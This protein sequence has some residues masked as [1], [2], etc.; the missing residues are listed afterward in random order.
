MEFNTNKV[1]K[2]NKKNQKK[3]ELFLELLIE[4]NFNIEKVKTGMNMKLL[5]LL[6]W[7]RDCQDLQDE[8]KDLE[9]PLSMYFKFMCYNRSIVG[10]TSKSV[11]FNFAKL[12]IEKLLK[13]S[14]S[15]ENVQNNIDYKAILPGEDNEQ[16]EILL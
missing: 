11:D 8:L 1:D 14:E 12:S 4:N 6:R 15:A 7:M 5:H 13:Q 9:E 3:I 16:I 2:I 10:S